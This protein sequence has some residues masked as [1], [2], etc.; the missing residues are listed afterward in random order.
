MSTSTAAA[1]AAASTP[2]QP[3]GAHL[4]H[5]PLNID[6]LRDL[7]R[8]EL[9]NVLDSVQGKKGLVLDPNLSGPLSLIA[10]FALLKD[11]GVEKIYHLQPGPL[12]TDCKN[13]IY[14]CRPQVNYMKYI[15][16][17]IHT[18]TTESR[19]GAYTYSLFFVPR[20]TALC[21]KVL[22]DEGVFGEITKGEY[23]LDLIP[24]EDDLLS[25]EWDSTFRELYLDK[26]T[27][28]IYYAAKALMRLQGIYGWFP[29]ILGKG[30]H[31]KALCDMMLRMRREMA[32]DDLEAS[33]TTQMSQNIDSLIILDRDVDLV[34]PLCTQLTYEGLIDEIF[35]IKNSFVEVDAAL[36]SATPAQSGP[37]GAGSSSSATVTGKKKKVPLNGG[38]KLFGELRDLNFAVVGG[39]LNKVAKRINADYEQRHNA[40][41]VPQ[42]RDFIN[43]MGGLAQ[44]HQSLRLHTSLAEQIMDYTMTDD[45]NR[46]LE[47]QQNVVAGIATTKEPDYIEEMINK[48]VP[49]VQVLR[50]LCLYSLVNNGLKPK[51]YE[52]FKKDILEAYGFEH[53]Q[54]LENLRKLGMLTKQVTTK[55]TYAL[56]RKSLSLIV[57]E[58]NEHAPNDISYVYSGYAPL[59]VRL[60]QCVVQRGKDPKTL[61]GGGGGKS[62]GVA[63]GHGWRG[64]EDVL[65]MLPGRTFDEKQ[66][67]DDGQPMSSRRMNGQPRISLVFFLGGCTFTEV[68]ATRF[69]ASQESGLRDFVICTTQILNGNTL[70]DSLVQ[71]VPDLQT[72]A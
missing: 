5:T 1:V 48:Q 19:S 13:L 11:H 67:V 26:D 39:L 42:I 20:R 28:S 15:A 60:I 27:T 47:V 62:S 37:G 31:S 33:Q 6:S 34:T 72:N 3:T 64:F 16:E 68:S 8:K 40:K 38:D 44:E 35:H 50:L 21:E 51:Q 29:R 4:G 70:V 58:V 61:G 56:V 49:I 45:F 36:A 46:I 12:E 57:D 63:G 54:T 66:R 69:L 25:L 22:E 55:N 41:T 2:A 10:E 53:I 32:V 24:L 18:H 14:I 59:S 65:R 17:H 71:K 52:S 9:V 7:A 23:H 43:K 30:E